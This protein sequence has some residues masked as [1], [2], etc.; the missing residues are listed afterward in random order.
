MSIG[1][2]MLGAN[3]VAVSYLVR[4]GSFDYLLSENAA[5]IIIKCDSYFITKCNR[6]L[7]QNASGLF[8]RKC[9]SCFTKGVAF[10]NC[11]NFITKFGSYYKLQVLMK[12]HIFFFKKKLDTNSL[13]LSI[14]IL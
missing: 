1:N 5:G 14:G 12:E 6:S 3:S 2:L 8:I 13:I 10:T 4:Y 9:D 11:N 7:L